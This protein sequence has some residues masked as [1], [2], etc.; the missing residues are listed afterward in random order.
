M[1]DFPAT[2]TGPVTARP[3]SNLAHREARFLAMREVPPDLDSA[4]TKAFAAAAGSTSPSPD[5]RALRR[6][7]EAL[8]QPS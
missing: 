5:Q 3:P 8:Y 7:G 1:N 4:F 6:T 2:V